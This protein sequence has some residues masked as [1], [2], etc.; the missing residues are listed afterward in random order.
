MT[1]NS[2]I[3]KKKKNHRIHLKLSKTITISKVQQSSN[4]KL[5]LYA[6]NYLIQ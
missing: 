6:A 1:I 4:N 5:P 2:I 3:K